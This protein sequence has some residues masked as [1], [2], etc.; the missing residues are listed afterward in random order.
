MPSTEPRSVPA[1]KRSPAALDAVRKSAIGCEYQIPEASGG[2]AVDFGKVN[3]IL[4]TSTLSPETLK[5]VGNAAACAN[6]EGWSY[7]D[8]AA[9]KKIS[10]CPASCTKAQSGANAKVDISLGCSTRKD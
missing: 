7:D 10:L 5:G 9:P 8:P 4:T 1:R 3:V 2:T 6:G